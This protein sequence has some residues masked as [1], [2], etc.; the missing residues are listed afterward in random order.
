[1][2]CWSSTD[3][4]LP[5]HEDQESNPSMDDAE[6]TPAYLT[7]VY[8]QPVVGE[9]CDAPVGLG[10]V[11]RNPESTKHVYAEGLWCR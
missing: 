4:A 1:M 11:C 8:Q 5:L 2:P 3:A 6:T 9:E 7:A 10:P